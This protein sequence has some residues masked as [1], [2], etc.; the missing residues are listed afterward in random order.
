MTEAAGFQD[1][2]APVTQHRIKSPNH[3]S[4]PLKKQESPFAEKKETV[5]SKARGKISEGG[6]PKAKPK[7]TRGGKFPKPK[8][9]PKGCEQADG[10]GRAPHP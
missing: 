4:N 8:K 6:F 10:K 7:Q 3:P 2:N 9:G 5:G 1:E